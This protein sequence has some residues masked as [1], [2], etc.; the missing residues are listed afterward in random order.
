MAQ[1]E[2]P[3]DGDGVNDGAVAAAESAVADAEAAVAAAQLHA[4]AVCLPGE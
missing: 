4:Q 1:H 2:N 3:N